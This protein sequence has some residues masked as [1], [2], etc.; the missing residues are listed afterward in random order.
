MA[1]SSP[2]LRLLGQEALALLARLGGVKPFALQMTAVPAACVS[3]A[4]QTAIETH[5]ESA[6]RK[7]RKM[8]LHFLRWLHSPEGQAESAERAQRRFTIV[9]VRFNAVLSQLDIFADVLV[10]RSEHDFGVWIAGLDV[11]AADAL[12][13]PGYYEAPPVIC[14]LDR[15]HGAA[16]R[17]ARTRLPGGDENPVAVIRVPRERMIGSGIA[18]SLIHEVGHQ[19]S[20][21]LDLIES[22]RREMR[23][24]PARSQSLPW[25]IWERCLSEILADFWSVA[26]VGISSTLGLIG[27]V[28]LPRAFVFRINVDDPHPFPWIRVKLS[29]AMGRALYPH[30]QWDRLEAIWESFYPTAGLDE[31]R[32]RLIAMLEDSVAEFVDL[33]VH[34]RPLSLRGRSL[35]EVVATEERQPE[36]LAAVFETW[37]SSP[38]RMRSVP[39]SLAFAAIG[40]ARAEER[41]S[42]AAETGLLTSLL[43]DWALQDSIDASARYAALPKLRTVRQTSAL[44]TALALN[45]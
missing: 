1:A 32:R 41:I 33:L 24:H 3:V 15:G 5:L 4:A 30:P 39:P 27:V 16:I 42:P 31:E 35:A 28:S 10:Q 37:R 7:L 25:T 45:S 23:E 40:Q 9:R 21:L 13:L 18:S 14:Y 44:A 2:A 17:R 8:T 34:H 11:V 36:R 38:Q 29:C 22:V 20:V 6:R 26:K 12:S 43:R 19:A